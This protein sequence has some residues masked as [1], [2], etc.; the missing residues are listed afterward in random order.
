[1]RF[2]REWFHI[3]ISIFTGHRETKTGQAR[4]KNPREI[5][6]KGVDFNKYIPCENEIKRSSAS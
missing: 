1:M 2:N 5:V 3:S 6:E 4:V